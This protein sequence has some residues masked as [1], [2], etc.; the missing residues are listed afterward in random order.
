MSYLCPKC[1]R[2]IYDRRLKTCGFCGAELPA[3]L[4]FTADEIAAMDKKEAALEESHQKRDAEKREEDFRQ[5]IAQRDRL[6]FG[7]GG[8]I[9]M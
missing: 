2:V 7:I 4:R 8:D 5:K 9:S 1:S 6:L 3:E